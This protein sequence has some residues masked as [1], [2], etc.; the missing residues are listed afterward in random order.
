MHPV[1]PEEEGSE[2]E[3]CGQDLRGP[4]SL[5]ERPPGYVNILRGGRRYPLDILIGER[6]RDPYTED[7]QGPEAT[8]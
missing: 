2:E 7:G 6:P 3:A 8:H 4:S 5:T 1:A